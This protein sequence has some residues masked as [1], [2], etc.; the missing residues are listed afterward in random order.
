[1]NT[2][3]ADRWRGVVERTWRPVALLAACLAI[4]H[5]VTVTGLV[6]AY[7]VPSPAKTFGLLVDKWSYLW[8]HTWVTTYE[9]MLGFAIA[10]VLGVLIA[11]VMVYSQTDREH[12]LPDPAVRAGHPEDRHRAAVRGVA[13]LRPRA[14][15]HR[16]RA[17]RLL[18]GGHLDGH[19]AA[20][21]STRRCSNCR[22][23]WAAARSRRSVKIRFPAVAAAPVRRPEGRRD[24]RRD[25]RRGRRV[26]RRQRG[27]RLRDPAGQRQPRHPDAVRRA[28]RHVA[29]RRRAVRPARGRRE[30]AAAV[31]RQPPRS[32]PSPHLLAKGGS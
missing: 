9:T 16:R 24:A 3:Q 20:S 17:D 29:H 22:R 1:M 31:A 13:R 32:P 2:V 4:W 11:V 7:L 23:R 10:G 19:R 6:E 14:E 25:R 26:R 18:P 27:P 8:Q 21:R 5:L 28:D 30:A 15:D 12:R